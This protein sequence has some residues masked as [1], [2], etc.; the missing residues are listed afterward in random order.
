MAE[1]CDGLDN[2]CDGTADEGD[3][4][5]GVACSTGL[6]GVC[7]SG[8]ETCQGGSLSCVQD[9]TAS[10]EICDGLDND[11]DGTP[12]DG[13]PIAGT[14]YF[15]GDIDGY[16]DPAVAA[17]LCGA[18]GGYVADNT[19]CGPSDSNTYPGAPEICDNIDNDCNALI[20]DSV[21]Q[22]FYLDADYD[23]FG[24]AAN[25][26]SPGCDPPLGYVR[27]DTDCDDTD[28]TINPLAKEIC[29]DGID[30]DCSAGDLACSNYSM[31][32]TTI[33]PIVTGTW[34]GYSVSGD[35]TGMMYREVL[36]GIVQSPETGHGTGDVREE[37]NMDDINVW[38]SW[39]WDRFLFQDTNGTVRQAA[40]WWED[41]ASPNWVT[42]TT[43]D[44][45]GG[46]FILYPSPMSVGLN[47]STAFSYD[48]T[49]AS[50]SY[51]YTVQATE[52]INTP[53]GDIQA[54]RITTTYAESWP[55][56]GTTPSEEYTENNTI[57]LHP[58]IG[59]VKRDWSFEEYSGGSSTP[60]D[61]G[62]LIWTLQDSSYFDTTV[63]CGG[64]GGGAGWVEKLEGTWY[65]GG[66][67]DFIVTSYHDYYV[68]LTMDAAGNI[69]LI[70]L[71]STDTTIT[72]IVTAVDD[73]LYTI[74]FND[75]SKGQIIVD[76]TFNYMVFIGNFGFSVHGTTEHSDIF[77]S[78]LQK[79][80]ASLPTYTNTDVDGLWNGFGYA[81]C[82]DNSF[83]RFAPGS[84]NISGT[85]ALDP[86][87]V[88]G[89]GFSQAQ[90][91]G[92]LS[93]YSQV[94]GWWDG[95]RQDTAGMLFLRLSPDKQFAGAYLEVGF[96]PLGTG[97]YLVP[98][99]YAFYAMH[100]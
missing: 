20:D 4:G 89:T 46:N 82:S 97:R 15:D 39:F 86:R 28:S 71:N 93:L 35:D 42:S 100:R 52:W 69:T 76:Q 98:E 53:A 37:F 54:F 3:P 81:Y 90:W 31:Q 94:L 60:W 21:A 70:N 38:G 51:A 79:G 48:T 23:G 49:G 22:V 58:E 72:G 96:G 68:T 55:A 6:L 64:A 78:V 30:Q 43:G 85:N 84:M 8:T 36:T 77:F 26:S 92:T 12:D 13:L 56:V 27:A 80:A 33:S 65:G 74:E 14:F 1:I 73:S 44:G 7:S 18:I 41:E 2:N 83:Y 25:V 47:G 32:A 10:A 29:E 11:C 63:S 87:T 91:T 67:D 34:W 50:A 45:G 88:S 99:D 24:A 61:W 75:A 59:E 40:M 57:W 66:I 16:G 9:V 62:N 19:D 17:P 5:G 95:T